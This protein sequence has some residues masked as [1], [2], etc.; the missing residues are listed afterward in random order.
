MEKKIFKFVLTGGPCAG[1]TTALSA[2][3]NIFAQH[4]YTVLIIPES[5]TELIISGVHPWTACK[6]DIIN[7]EYAITS[8][9]ISKENL[10]EKIVDTMPNDK[11]ILVYDRGIIDAASFLPKEDFEKVLSKF[12]LTTATAMSRYDAVFH[13]VTAA[14]GASEFYTLANNEARSETPEQAIALDSKTIKA[15]TGHQHLRIIDNSTDFSGKINRLIAEIFAALGEP[16][17]IE[18]ER[19]FLI[20]YPD[21]ELISKQVD[22]TCLDI[23]QTYLCSKDP[24]IE[25]RIRQR[26]IENNFTYY[27]TEKRNFSDGK[28]IETEKKISEQDYLSL[29]LEA[30]I[31]LH[32]IIKKRYCFVFKNQYFELDI[33]PFSNTNAILEIE[34]TDATREV[35]IPSFIKVVKEVTNDMSY[36]NYNLAKSSCL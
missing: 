1:K 10:Y 5:A 30:D 17:P 25:R 19:K 13:L 14:N 22:L 24:E 28:R 35:T 7:F 34:L 33:Y 11:I 29:L 21:L 36:K 27:Y 32:Q 31:R 20:E 4:G 26:G 12:S 9:Q 6:E 2:I 15:W 16:V 23:V 3:S 8:K 18:D